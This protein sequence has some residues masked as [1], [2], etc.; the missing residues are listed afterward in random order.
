MGP[1]DEVSQK[2]RG[3]VILSAAK[4][5]RRQAS[6][7]AN[8][9]LRCAQDDSVERK[10]DRGGAHTPGSLPK[11]IIAFLRYSTISKNVEI[12]KGE[13]AYDESYTG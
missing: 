8:Q 12:R 10:D 4:D 5:L 7:G 6:G 9:I 13:H 11:S 3:H 1:D 2:K